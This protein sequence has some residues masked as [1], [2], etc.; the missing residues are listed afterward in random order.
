MDKPVDST[1]ACVLLIEPDHVA[2][3]SIRRAVAAAGGGEIRIQRVENLPIASARLGGG[4]VDV[5]ILDLSFDGGNSSDR[6]AVF[7]RLR[8]V[9]P[10]VPI[11]VLYDSHEEGLALKAMRAGSAD[12]VL[13]EGHGEALGRSIR[14]VIEL[15]RKRAET[16]Q[17]QSRGIAARQTGGVV[18]F[19]GAKGGVGTTTVALNVAAAL[20]RQSKVTLV[21]MR[22]SFGTLLPYLKPHGQV[23]SN[24]DLLR[25]RVGEIGP[26]EVRA[27]LTPCRNVPGLSVSYGP[28]AAAECGEPAPDRVKGLIKVLGHLSDYAVLDLPASLSDANRAA[29]EASAQVILVTER[30]PVSIRLAGLMAQAIEAWAGAPQPIGIVVVD[31]IPVGRPMPLSEVES[32]LGSSPIA[33]I[34]PDADIC[35]AAQHAGVPL[36]AFEPDGLVS[37]RLIELA[38]KCGA[39]I[40]SLPAVA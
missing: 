27:C 25:E 16:D 11:V 2:A 30:D 8:E 32:R 9:A 33:V 24:S 4:G 36:I 40:R 14:S 37:G 19:I 21:E 23:R 6:L 12:Y 29:V 22:P 17:S 5:V 28:Q 3:E 38:G 34:P 1:E 18:S 31:C 39:F 35:L 13:K 15:G 26:E 7:L 20:A 10:Q